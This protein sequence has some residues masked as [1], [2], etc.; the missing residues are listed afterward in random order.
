[1]QGIN[2]KEFR[3]HIYKKFGTIDYLIEGFSDDELD[4]QR[5]LSVKFKWGHNHDFGDFKVD[6][7]MGDRHIILMAYFLKLFDIDIQY[8][9]QKKV[10]DIGCWTGGTTLLLGALGSKVDAIEEVKKYADMTGFLIKSFGLDN[11]LSVKSNSLYELN[12]EQYESQYDIVYFPG[13]LYHL[14]DPILALRI[15]YNSLK[16]NGILLLETYGVNSP[17]PLCVYEGPNVFPNDGTNKNDLNR[18]G[19]KLL[20]S[21]LYRLRKNDWGCWFCFYSNYI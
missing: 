12:N 14:S 4:K 17:Q 8:F 10:L 5:D 16:D 21:I 7:S 13:V 11:D 9:H 1:M 18:G 2:S 15:L 6:G 19:W 3:D 20:Y